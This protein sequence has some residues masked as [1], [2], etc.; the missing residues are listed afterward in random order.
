V[1]RLLGRSRYGCED[2]IKIDYK[3]VGSDYVVRIQVAQN[4]LHFPALVSTVNSCAV[5]GGRGG[6]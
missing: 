2:N 4:R 3:E 5:K 6:Y 1:T